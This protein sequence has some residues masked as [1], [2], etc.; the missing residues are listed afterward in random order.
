MS[1][2]AMAFWRWFG[3]LMILTP[4]VARPIAAEWRIMRRS[5]RLLTVLAFL[6]VGAFNT[7]SYTGLESTTATNGVAELCHPG[8]D[9]HHRRR[10]SARAAECLAVDRHSRVFYGRADDRRARGSMET[11]LRLRLNSGDLWV[12]RRCCAGPLSTIC[13]R[14]R[15]PG[16]SSRAFTGAVIAIGVML[17]L[18]LFLWDYR[19]GSRTNWDAATLG[20]VAYFAIF[21]SVLAY[22]FWNA[23]V[24]H[25]GGGACRDFHPSDARLRRGARIRFSRR[26]AVVVSLCGRSAHL[27]GYL[28]GFA[29]SLDDEP[30]RYWSH[31]SLACTR[32][33]AARASHFSSFTART[34]VRGAGTS[35]S[36]RGSACVVIPRAPSACA[37]T[38]QARQAQRW[39]SP[40]STIT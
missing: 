6:G 25:C 36:C 11:L 13:L 34:P 37:G 7:L 2:V 5:W 3:A 14:W 39:I 30:T 32:R 17:L 28:R 4:F 15:P 12:W 23:A 9:H 22:F 18:P 24:A 16:L 38:A 27:L 21:P 31:D 35:T 1:P 33:M 26:S 19:A 8:I 29:F 40:D 20:A 10:V